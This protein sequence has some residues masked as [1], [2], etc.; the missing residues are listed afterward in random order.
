MCRFME[1]DGAETAFIL[2]QVAIK[3][4]E[5]CDEAHIYSFLEVVP[6]FDMVRA[7]LEFLVIWGVAP[8]CHVK[9]SSRRCWASIPYI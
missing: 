1:E 2:A 6:R 7:S 3:S 4:F 9:S 8:S 5:S